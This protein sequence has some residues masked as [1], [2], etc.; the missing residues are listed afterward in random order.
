[1]SARTLQFWF[2]YGSTY[3]YLTVSRI[4][5]LAESQGTSLEWRPFNMRMISREL[6]LAKGPFGENPLKLQYMWRDV[7]RRAALHGLE[8]KKPTMYPVDYQLTS[9]VGLCAAQEGWCP[10]FT[11][12]VFRWNF[13]DGRPIGAEGNL[14][15]AIRALNKDPQ[16]VI[17]KAQSKETEDQMT[18]QTNKARA[19]GIFGSPTFAVEAELFWGDDRLEQA[20][21]WCRAH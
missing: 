1:M 8:Y 14:E 12:L 10:E 5:R 11:R 19:L 13:V 16:M 15:A 3:T 2:S 4:E 18:E 6:G 9:R 17:A 20:L 21:S 7:E